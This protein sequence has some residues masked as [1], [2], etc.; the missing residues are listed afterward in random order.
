[1]SKATAE[2]REAETTPAHSRPAAASSAT[3]EQPFPSAILFISPVWPDQSAL[4]R[5]VRCT[6]RTIP[7]ASYRQALRRLRRS[8]VPIVFCDGNLPDGT[9]LDVLNHIGDS[10]D[11]P[12]LIVTSRLADDRL[13]AEV[14]NLGGFDVIAKPFVASKVLH[15]LHTA[16]CRARHVS[17]AA[18]PNSAYSAH[19]AGA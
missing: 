14:L 13:W 5:I 8:H 1:M 7:A 15:V 16:T 19:S 6:H 11:P 3:M 2:L 12:L 10:D 17:P 4:R 9:W 18:A